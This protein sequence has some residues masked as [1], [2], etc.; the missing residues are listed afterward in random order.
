MIISRTVTIISTLF[1]PEGSGAELS[2]YLLS[3]ELVKVN[4]DINVISGTKSKSILGHV[5]ERESK[6][7]VI[8]VP[9]E[10]YLYNTRYIHMDLFYK[11]MSYQYLRDLIKHSDV[12][13]TNSM[14]GILV[15]K[16]LG[17]PTVYH[18]HTY[19]PVCKCSSHYD[20]IQD[21]LEPCSMKSYVYTLFLERKYSTRTLF[22]L[23]LTPCMQKI[24]KYV[25]MNADA[26]VF[27]SSTQA[28]LILSKF[29]LKKQNAY[30]VPNLLPLDFVH[31]IES[32]NKNFI[33]QGGWS[34]IK[35]FYNIL[36]ALKKLNKGIK[37]YATR[38]SPKNDAPVIIRINDSTVHLLPNLDKTQYEKIHEFVSS[39][40]VP[41]LW[42]ETF[43]YNAIES[44]LR[45]KIVISS[46]RGAIREVL[47]PI[48]KYVL[49]INPSN[50]DTIVEAIEVVRSMSLEEINNIGLKQRTMLLK[51]YDKRKIIKKI[52]EIFDKVECTY[53]KS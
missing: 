33:Y 48:S 23:A 3:R 52:I 25:Y 13:F 8:R 31:F 49:W 47:A 20:V 39:A 24:Y 30:V 36:I 46:V 37:L 44:A 43:S 29:N 4:Y 7:R 28:K 50:I 18:V 51:S 27:V 1:Y 17:V 38:T 42:P 21:K 34:Y 6:I 40:I 10:R 15:G 9:L 19:E 32:K 45:G 26:I 11:I 12:I 5:F 53:G 41:S 35:G 14:A 22:A 16:I 2:M